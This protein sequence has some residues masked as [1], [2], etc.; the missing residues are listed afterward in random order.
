[1]E[2]VFSGKIHLA[3]TCPSAL[4]PAW[5]PGKRAGPESTAERAPMRKEVALRTLALLP[6]H[7]APSQRSINAYE[8]ISVIAQVLG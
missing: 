7:W 8:W 2:D 5:R 4:A 1:M 6:Q 3:G